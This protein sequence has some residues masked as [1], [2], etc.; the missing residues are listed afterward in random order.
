MIKIDGEDPYT[1]TLGPLN[2]K[3]SEFVTEMTKELHQRF[4]TNEGNRTDF[5]PLL[6]AH[7]YQKDHWHLYLGLMRFMQERVV[8]MLANDPNLVKFR[9]PKRYSLSPLCR[10]QLQHIMIGNMKS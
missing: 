8:G 4:P 6:F 5:R 3:Q 10:F 9:P 1:G 7:S 2:K